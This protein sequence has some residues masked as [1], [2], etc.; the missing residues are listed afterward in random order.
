MI[1]FTHYIEIPIKVY[2]E[3]QP[4]ESRTWNYP[5]CPASVWIEDIDVC[6]DEDHSAKDLNELKDYILET[7]N[8]QLKDTA[9]EN[10]NGK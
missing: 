7:Y 3:Y 2:A 8:D 6:L 4:G 9:W 5:G 1:E 10:K